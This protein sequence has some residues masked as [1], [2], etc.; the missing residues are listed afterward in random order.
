[1]SP[2]EAETFLAGYLDEGRRNMEPLR[3]FAALGHVQANF[4]L[5]TLPAIM[6]AVWRE[7]EFVPAEPDEV[8]RIFPALYTGRERRV[9]VRSR[10]AVATLSYYLGESFVRSYPSRLYWG[11]GDSETIHANHPAVVGFA[12]GLDMPVAPVTQ[13]VLIQ[14]AEKREPP[15]PH[16][17]RFIE[18]W[19]TL[20]EEDLAGIGS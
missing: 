15:I 14:A 8:Q 9:G 5:A 3:E 11:L 10:D 17:E 2:I 18:Y 6:Y 16:F 4:S 20:A 12:K 1:M 19:R 7:I 13:N